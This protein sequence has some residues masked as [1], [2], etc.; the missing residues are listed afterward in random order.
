M[1]YLILTIVIFLQS[2]ASAQTTDVYRKIVDDIKNS[3]EY[4]GFTNQSNQNCKGLSVSKYKYSVCSFGSFFKDEDIKT[5][6]DNECNEEETFKSKKNN[7]LKKFSDTGETCF[8]A[9]FSFK[10]KNK[11]AVKIISKS[12]ED[13]IGYESLHFLYDVNNNQVRKL[14]SIEVTND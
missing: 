3:K 11:I 6:M 2:C 1:K 12:D 13:K 8:I 5:F 9:D 14:E 4:E 7:A 10:V